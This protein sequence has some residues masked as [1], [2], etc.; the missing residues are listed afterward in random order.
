MG[1]GENVYIGW[2]WGARVC[3]GGGGTQH[4]S[5]KLLDLQS[6]RACPPPPHSSMAVPGFC[7]RCS[8][9]YSWH[10]K[11]SSVNALLTATCCT[12]VSE[13]VSSSHTD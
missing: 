6:A 2:Y 7:N 4:P 9:E 11:A 12:M 10:P 1:R 3:V 5:T 8:T 13:L